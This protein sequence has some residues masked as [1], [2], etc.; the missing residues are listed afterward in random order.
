MVLVSCCNGLFLFNKNPENCGKVNV[1]RLMVQSLEYKV[2]S[3]IMNSI[4]RAKAN[5][6]ALAQLLATD[7]FVG[8]LWVAVSDNR[9]DRSRNCSPHRQYR[10]ILA[11]PDIED[12]QS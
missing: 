3:L 2:Y 12:R 11:K 10:R 4:R 8:L 9:K 7:L 1:L 6:P 5:T